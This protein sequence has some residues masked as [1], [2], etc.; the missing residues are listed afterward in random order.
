MNLCKCEAKEVHANHI[1]KPPVV[2]YAEHSFLQVLESPYCLILRDGNLRISLKKIQ[3]C[4]PLNNSEVNPECL[5]PPLRKFT[6]ML[7]W[8]AFNTVGL[9]VLFNIFLSLK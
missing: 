8:H 1:P 2:L 9:K 4:E 5:S 7:Y 3:L 6:E